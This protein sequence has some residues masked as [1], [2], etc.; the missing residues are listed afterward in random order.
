MAEV[1][2][3]RLVTRNFSWDELVGSQI[4]ARRGIN[5]EP[6]DTETI[7]SLYRLA[8]TLQYL[9]DQ[10]QTPIVIT[11]AYRSPEVNAIVGGADIS[12]HMRGLAA[13]IIA[14]GV[15]APLELARRIVAI[16]GWDWDQ[17]I[18]EFRRWVHISIGPEF[19]RQVLT[20]DRTGVQQGLVP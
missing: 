12:H 5:N 13:D 14:P 9:R 4:A 10:L 17:V 8:D 2:I 18:L 20:I 3:D 7:M 15:G 19:R 16:P 1:V 11:S 6:R